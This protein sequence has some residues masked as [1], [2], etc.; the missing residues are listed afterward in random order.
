MSRLD[1]RLTELGLAPSRSKAQQLIEA[2]EVQIRKNGQWETARQTSFKTD[3][4]RAEDIRLQAEPRTLK[5]VSRGGLKLESA[6]DHLKLDVKHWRILDVGLSTGG[7]SDCLLQRGAGA[8]AGVD[9]GHGQLHP[10]LQVRSA[11]QSFEGVNVKDLP[12][13]ESV[14]AYV[15][16]GVD[17]CVVD[18]SFIS[19]EQVLPPLGQLLP[20]DT[21]LL[22]LVKPQ[23][24]VGAEALNRKGIVMD[25]TLFD[26]VRG[27]VLRALA[28]YG[29][30]QE[31][32]F[33]CAVK[34]QD[35][36]QEFFVYARR[37]P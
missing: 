6:L 34:G 14:R 3:Q 21:R 26:D 7:F 27:R 17:L 2:G 18:V 31:D 24:E 9:V 22:A 25:V 28:K 5:Y 37:R 20:L 36:N 15:D 10:S 11:L 1:L 29:F 4:L 35:G 30:S 8:I 13:H 32:Y 23:F 19:L 12:Q 16:K 33:P